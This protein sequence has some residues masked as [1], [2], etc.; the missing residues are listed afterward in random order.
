ML[1]T[2]ALTACMDKEIEKR[3]STEEGNEAT[4]CRRHNHGRWAF[5]PPS[6]SNLYSCDFYPYDA[7]A[8]TLTT[9]SRLNLTKRKQSDCDVTSPPRI[10]RIR[11]TSDYR[12]F[13]YRY[14]RLQHPDE[15]RLLVLYSGSFSD[16]IKCRLDHV[17]LAEEPP[18]DALSYAWGDSSKPRTVLCE[19]RAIP[20]T[21]S[22]FSAP[23]RLRCQDRDRVLWADAICIYS[24]RTRMKHLGKLRLVTSV[25]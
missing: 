11:K 15:I 2:K 19:N 10:K 13:P 23:R 16:P 9:M 18:Y 4:E 8:N 3:M 1:D 24:D 6:R 12:K 14:K 20:V 21:G 7:V 17:R 22:L 5:S 25:F